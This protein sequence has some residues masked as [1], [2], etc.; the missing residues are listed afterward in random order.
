MKKLMS[1]VLVCIMLVLS[2]AVANAQTVPRL[3]NVYA[4]GML[5]QQ[6]R[7]AVFAGEA[8]TG[9]KV[10]VSLYNSAGALAA[11]GEG[12]A[13]NGV[14]SVS[15]PAPEGSFERYSVRLSADGVEFAVLTDVVFGVLW[16]A[17]GQSNMEYYLNKTPEG[18]EMEAAGKTGSADIHVLQV[19]VPY[20]NGGYR[21]A[22]LPQTDIPGCSWFTADSAQVYQMSAVAYFFAEDLLKDLNMPVGVLNAAVGGSAIASWVSRA[23]I[24]SD[25]AAKNHL[26]ED[27]SYYDESRWSSPD[28]SLLC[29]MTNLYNTNIAPLTHFRPEGAIWYQ[30]CTDLIF[31]HS[32]DYYKSLFNLMQNSYTADFGYTGGKLPIVFSQI[33]YYI[34]P[35]GPFGVTAFNEA[36]TAL[37]K[38]DPSCRA[39]IPIYDL[40]L[41]F[42]EM[43]AIQPMTKKPIGQRMCLSAEALVYGAA[44]PAGAAVCTGSRVTG[45]SVYL[46]FENTG[47]GL[48][49]TSDVPRGFAVC[50][51]DG[52]AVEAQAEIVDKNTVRVFSPYVPAPVAATYAVYGWSERANLWSSWRGAPYLPAA[53]YGIDSKDVKRHYADNAWMNC[54]DAQF[55]ESDNVSPGYID[56]W[57][58]SN[59]TVTHSSGAVS[60]GL[61]AMRIRSD[62]YRFTVSPNIS[63]KNKLE[64]VVFDNADG[65]YS[66]YHTLQLCVQNCGRREVRLNEI[67][68]YT[69]ALTYYT[70]VCGSTGYTGVTLPADGA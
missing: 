23:A 7:D 55:F 34:Y 69:G 46:T 28:R 54:D 43:G 65:D 14:F 50:G 51:A 19:P 41:A 44:Q 10:N 5:F 33:A 36:F 60:E 38:E 6:K 15:F 70:P 45:D 2:V 35:C 27:G 31:D 29:D 9:S 40:S 67:R 47:D 59:C 22:Y 3:Y 32:V 52:I 53:A 42:N 37:A 48:C 4:S 64:T 66:S 12:T 16:L 49:F 1:I 26:I 56:S 58:A 8:K 62:A 25:A 39:M 13:Q 61:A 24:D 21:T 57:S 63:V 20:E 17:F 30:G 11:S 68:F 18:K